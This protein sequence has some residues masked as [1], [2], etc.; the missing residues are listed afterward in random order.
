MNMTATVYTPLKK[1]PAHLAAVMVIAISV[2]TI[3]GLFFYMQQQQL[4]K[5]IKSV[6][7]RLIDLKK[8]S[9]EFVIA[10]LPDRKTLLDIKSR[11]TEIRK[12]W[13]QTSNWQLLTTLAKLEQHLPDNATVTR[14]DFR[15]DTG[16][17]ELVTEAQGNAALND[18][19][20]AL[21]DDSHFLK[22]LLKKQAHRTSNKTT[23][24]QYIIHLRISSE[25]SQ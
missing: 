23:F 21:E 11:T 19:L 24:D 17:I 4:Q 5:E 10:D 12:L 1:G 2:F 9:Q 16:F 3:S 8:R 14:L 7:N 18:F 6:Q 25:V 22:V 13:Q 15:R 20:K